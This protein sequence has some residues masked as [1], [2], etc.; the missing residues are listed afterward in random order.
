MFA[1]GMTQLLIVAFV[2]LLF[3][4]NRLPG[5]MRSVGTSIRSFKEG[6][7]EDSALEEHSGKA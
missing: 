6:L 4:G 5:A 2:A 1:P 3:F 7:K